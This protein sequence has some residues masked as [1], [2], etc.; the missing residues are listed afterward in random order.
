MQLKMACF[1]S[2]YFFSRWEHLGHAVAAMFDR[3]NKGDVSYEGARTPT[4]GLSIMNY[5]AS[6]VRT[7]TLCLI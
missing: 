5:F 7:S 2:C 4:I 1:F 6:F 3:L